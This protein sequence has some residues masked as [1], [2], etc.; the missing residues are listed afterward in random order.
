MF[1]VSRPNI[2]I[3]YRNR[4]RIVSSLK[5]HTRT[6]RGGSGKA[7]EVAERVLPGRDPMVRDGRE[8]RP[9]RVSGRLLHRE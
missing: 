1:A 8:R 9:R 5:N 7:R 4:T 6:R 3:A 2:H